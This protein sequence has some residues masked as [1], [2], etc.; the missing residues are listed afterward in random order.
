[1]SD[2]AR[3]ADTHGKGAFAGLCEVVATRMTDLG[4][5]GVAI[6]VL[7]QGVERTAGFGVTSVENPLPVDT[8]TLFQIGSITKTFVGTAVM[9]LV[10]KGA[11]ELN[12]PVRTYLPNL[13]LADE[14]AA[15]RVTVTH[16][17]THTAGWV[18]DYFDDFGPGDDALATMVGRMKMLP[19]L[20]PVGEVWSYNNA[21]FY[22]AGRVLEVVTGS[23]FEEVIRELVLEPLGMT[24]TYLF[25]QGYYEVNCDV[26]VA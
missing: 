4:V 25:P 23:T 22:L 16:L 21:A 6:G 19:Q 20:T 12:V 7:H 24:R 10:E 14:D 17:L 15:S 18:G 9:R 2:G 26:R 8:D 5:P 3:S 1:M 11:I 13:Q